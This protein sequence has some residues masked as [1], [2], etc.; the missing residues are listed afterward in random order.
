[1]STIGYDIEIDGIDNLFSRVDTLENAMKTEASS[2][3]VGLGKRIVQEIKE[4]YVP[5]D[6]GLEILNKAGERVFGGVLGAKEHRGFAP[7]H[8]SNIPQLAEGLEK[9]QGGT[10]RDSVMSS[11]EPEEFGEEGF[12]I[13]IW[14]G[15]PGSGAEEYAAIQHENLLYRHLVGQAKYIEIPVLLLAPPELVPGIQKAIGKAIDSAWR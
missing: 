10:L 1:M 7:V 4:N 8:I 3:F 13:R 2:I 11:D 5:V 12:H 9:R 6:V 15:G 14:A